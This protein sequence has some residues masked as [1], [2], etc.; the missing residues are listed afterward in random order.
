MLRKSF[1][2]SIAAL[3]ALPNPVL[4]EDVVSTSTR[5]IS[6]SNTANYW[7]S[8]R[9]RTA[10]PLPL[11]QP[12]KTS[13]PAPAPTNTGTSISAKGALPTANVAPNMENRLF[14]PAEAVN[15]K[16]IQP[17]KVGTSGAHFTSSQ[18]VPLTNDLFYPYRPVGKL[19][20]TKPDVGD[21]VCSASVVKPRVILTAG[22]C[23]HKGSGGSSGFYKNFLFIPA[24]RDGTAPLQSWTSTFVNTTATWANGGGALPNAA[25]YAMIELEDRLFGKSVLKIGEVT[26]YLGFRTLALIPN[27]ATI[28]GYPVN[29]DSGQKIHQVTAGSFRSQYAD[30]A[31][32][33]SDMGEGSSGGPMIEN[34]GIPA[35]GQTAGLNNVPNQIIGV[36]SY[37]YTPLDPLIQGSSIPD[38]RFVGILNAICARRTDNCATP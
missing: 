14:T 35:G 34:F 15:N 19:F 30:T 1:A 26:G 21:F 33:G 5:S 38:S 23:V 25:D 10:K 16:Q 4:A 20:F 17:M 29:L 12:K 7:T 32:Y 18:L 13:T 37:G 6:P 28:L 2:F 9:L 36:I 31:E 11:G 3:A 24:F 8:E 27:H 22:H